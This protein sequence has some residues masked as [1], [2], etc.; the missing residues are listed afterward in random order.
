LIADPR[1]RS[2]GVGSN[3]PYESET[4]RKPRQARPSWSRLDTGSTPGGVARREAWTTATA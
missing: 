3:Q 2:V 1:P 4:H